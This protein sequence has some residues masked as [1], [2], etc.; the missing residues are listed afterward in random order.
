MYLVSD[1]VFT[2]HFVKCSDDNIYW[3]KFIVS[4]QTYLELRD[5]F[6]ASDSTAGELYRKWQSDAERDAGGKY[7]KLLLSDYTW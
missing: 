3:H 7:N 6:H 1:K 2:K 5:S 4:G